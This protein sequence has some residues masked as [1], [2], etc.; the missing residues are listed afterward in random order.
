MQARPLL[1]QMPFS[2]QSGAA[3]HPA[4]TRS[5]VMVRMNPR[6]LMMTELLMWMS[7]P[8]VADSRSA[9]RLM[10]IK[11]T[12]SPQPHR[13]EAPRAQYCSRSDVPPWSRQ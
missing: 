7:A 4:R 10:A 11:K 1:L 5:S 9:R 6:N 3:P 13:R 2:E 12:I 8:Y